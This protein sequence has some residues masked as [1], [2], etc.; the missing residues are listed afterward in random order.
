MHKIMN[1]HSQK[2][3]KKECVSIYEKVHSKLGLQVGRFDHLSKM[4]SK[5]CIQMNVPL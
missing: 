5:V 2:H 4:E 1:T 3:F